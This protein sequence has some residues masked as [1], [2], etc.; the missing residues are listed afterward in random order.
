MV[1][2]S[3][4]HKHFK[5]PLRQWSKNPGRQIGIFNCVPKETLVTVKCID[6][7]RKSWSELAV[8]LSDLG[9]SCLRNTQSPFFIIWH[10]C[11]VSETGHCNPLICQINK[12]FKLDWLIENDCNATFMHQ[13]QTD[14]TL[15]FPNMCGGGGGGGEGGGGRVGVDIWSFNLYHSLG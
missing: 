5:G 2:T 14:G 9:I 8:V 4:E 11:P 6:K 7:Q 15:N 10:K 13:G 1:Q 12:N 3:N